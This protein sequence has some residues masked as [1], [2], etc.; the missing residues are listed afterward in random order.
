MLS[1]PLM[2]NMGFAAGPPGV[3]APPPTIGTL[4]ILGTCLAMWFI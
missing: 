2:M 3:I 1:F 4:I